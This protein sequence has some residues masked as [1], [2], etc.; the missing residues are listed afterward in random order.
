MRAIVFRL[1][2]TFNS[3]KTPLSDKITSDAN[4]R[5]Y[6]LRHTSFYKLEMKEKENRTNNYQINGNNEC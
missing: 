5:S 6:Q 1:I 2:N 4:S 3:D